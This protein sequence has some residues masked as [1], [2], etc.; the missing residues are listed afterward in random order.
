MRFRM[1]RMCFN[2]LLVNSKGLERDSFFMVS[3]NTQKA[4]DI[5]SAFYD[6]STTFLSRLALF[7]SVKKLSNEPTK[8]TLMEKLR[9]S[10]LSRYL[11]T[12]CKVFC[13][14]NE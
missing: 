11:L 4:A 10:L 12:P 7:V 14:T 1:Q 13:T 3:M 6:L 2:G 9:S 5:K 8:D